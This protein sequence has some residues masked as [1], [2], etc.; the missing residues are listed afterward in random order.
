MAQ[1]ALEAATRGTLGKRGHRKPIE[2]RTHEARGH[3]RGASRRRTTEDDFDVNAAARQVGEQGGSTRARPARGRRQ[4]VPNGN[5][6]IVGVSPARRQTMKRRRTRPSQETAVRRC[7]GTRGD[8]KTGRGNEESQP[9]TTVTRA[10]RRRVPSEGRRPRRP[11]RRVHERRCRTA[12]A[13]RCPPASPPRGRR[14]SHS[15]FWILGSA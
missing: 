4:P 15:E 9:H 6:T 12:H 13:S 8:R 7:P 10:P 5:P 11:D 1:R 14:R 3:E 2:P